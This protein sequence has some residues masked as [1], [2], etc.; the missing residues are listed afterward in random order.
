MARYS[1]EES[2]KLRHHILEVAENII[3]KDGIKK[4]TMRKLAIKASVSQTT[5]YNIFGTKG[6]LIIDIL[7]NDLFTDMAVLKVALTPADTISEL[8]SNID[9]L[10]ALVIKKEQFIKSLLVGIMQNITEVNSKPLTDII[11]FYAT[12]WVQ[13]KIDEGFLKEDADART[14]GK[15]ITSMM[16]GHVLLWATNS[17][18]LSY[19]SMQVKY[20][21]ISVVSDFVK[22]KHKPDI[23]IMIEDIITN[24]I[25]AL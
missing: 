9:K 18:P 12:H 2:L 25:K 13:G 10:E 19:L 1:T 24:Q 5:P 11:E 8:F 7:A 6:Q 20:S 17:V 23:Q 4:L 3:R 16:A 15:L 21:I 22:K 14:L